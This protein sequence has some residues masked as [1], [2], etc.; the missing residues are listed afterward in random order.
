[1]AE[2]S[3][4]I[5]AL[6]PFPVPLCVG[7]AAAAEILQTGEGAE[8]RRRVAGQRDAFVE[9][10]IAST[11]PV[12]INGPTGK[13][14]HPGNANLQFNG[15]VAQEILGALQ[16]HLAALHWLRLHIRHP[17]TLARPARHRAFI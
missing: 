14:R 3:R 10:L 9:Q 12:R 5:C 6:A 1:M 13:R 7:M 4:T 8:E 15:F 16:P 11:Y 17:G 2:D